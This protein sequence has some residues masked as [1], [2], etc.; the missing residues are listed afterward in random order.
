M[1]WPTVE[2]PR[3]YSSRTKSQRSPPHYRVSLELVFDVTKAKAVRL[4][5]LP[6]KRLGYGQLEFSAKFER[7]CHT[8]RRNGCSSHLGRANQE[9]TYS[10]VCVVVSRA[11]GWKMRYSLR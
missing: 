8:Q 9:Q 4:V 11:G 5:T 7:Y 1:G 2:Y 10:A 3:I 6:P